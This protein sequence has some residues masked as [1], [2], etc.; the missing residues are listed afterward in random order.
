MGFLKTISLL[1]LLAFANCKPNQPEKLQSQQSVSVATQT[2]PL[3]TMSYSYDCL[4]SIG[5]NAEALK[6]DALK[7]MQD[8]K[9]ALQSFLNGKAGYPETY[10]S[11]VAA[12]KL[13]NEG[14]NKKQAAPT[15]LKILNSRIQR[16]EQN[17]FRLEFCGKGNYSNSYQL[18]LKP[19]HVSDNLDDLYNQHLILKRRDHGVMPLDIFKEKYPYFP[20]NYFIR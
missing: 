8:E 11:G 14:R 19:V 15:V 18:M 6:N 5:I 16:L 2:P 20:I 1:S 4:Q 10:L 13:A 12:M 7:T 3:D 9:A 17:Q